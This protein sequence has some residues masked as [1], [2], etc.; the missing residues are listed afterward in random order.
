MVL[1]YI[2]IGI[3]LIVVG[4]LISLREFRQFRKDLKS[5]RDTSFVLIK[6]LLDTFLFGGLGFA[7]VILLLI[8][9]IFTGSGLKLW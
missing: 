5:D 9:L 6:G 7:G 3:I 4:V 8:G 2:L 1:K